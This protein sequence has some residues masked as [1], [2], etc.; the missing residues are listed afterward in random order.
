MKLAI[1]VLT[2][3]LLSAF[4]SAE[5]D[6]VIDDIIIAVTSDGETIK[7]QLHFGPKEAS[8]CFLSGDVREGTSTN[9]KSKKKMSIAYVRDGDALIIESPSGICDAGAETKLTLVNGLYEGD[10]YERSFYGYKVIGF[11]KQVR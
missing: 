3:L 11:V 2:V 10:L 4:K 7:W 5:A 1:L 6:S 9:I 8:S